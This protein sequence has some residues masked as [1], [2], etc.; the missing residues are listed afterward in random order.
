MFACLGL[1]LLIEICF[2]LS[3]LPAVA[4]QK[5]PKSRRRLTMP[6]MF[7]LLSIWL[8]QVS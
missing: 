2:F 4:K 1:P 7:L 6:S 5:P 8:I 3:E